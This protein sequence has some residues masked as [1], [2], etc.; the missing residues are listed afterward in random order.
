[1]VGEAAPRPY[2]NGGIG[3][4]RERYVSVRATF[5]TILLV[6]AAIF[7]NFAPYLTAVQAE[8]IYDCDTEFGLGIEHDQCT[9]VDRPLRHLPESMFQKPAA[10]FEDWYEV[11]AELVDWFGMP[12]DLPAEYDYFARW[13][14]W[15]LWIGV[16]STALIFAVLLVVGAYI[17]AVTAKP[18]DKRA[19][20]T[21]GRVNG[22]ETT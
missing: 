3:V 18:V 6:I 4:F 16:Y 17:M 1:M 10:W 9:F 21:T 19:T 11:G 2:S 22:D 12:G 5:F 13:Q 20:L 8:H 15:Y 7:I 14:R